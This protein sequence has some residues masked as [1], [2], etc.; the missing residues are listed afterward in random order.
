[1][2]SVSL[3]HFQRYFYSIHANL[4]ESVIE[5]VANIVESALW[6]RIKWDVKLKNG[7][8]LKN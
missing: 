6:K 3:S 5:D 4:P 2:D 7:K 8:Y 1:M